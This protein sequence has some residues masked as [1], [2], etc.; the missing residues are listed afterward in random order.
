MTTRRTILKAGLTAGAVA[1]FSGAL[2]GLNAIAQSAPRVRRSLHGMALDDPDLVAYR[3]FVG[4]ML[5]KDQNDP[6]SWLQYSLMHGKYNGNYRYCPHGDWYFL[7]WHREFVIMYE[8]AAMA[9]TGKQDFAMPYWDWSIDRVMPQAFTDPTYQGKPNPLYVPGRT[10]NTSNWPLPDAWVAPEVLA[11]KVYAETNFQLF[12]TSKNP[13]QND[14]D[15]RWVVRGGGSQGFLEGTPHNL[16]HNSIGAYMPTAGSP[17]DPIFMMHHSN[18]DRIWAV[19]NALGRS[20]TADMTPSDRNLWLNMYFNANYLSP[21]GQVYGAYP[22][23]LQD[24]RVLGYTYPN[25]P[26]PD[27]LLSDPKRDA[28]LMSLLAAGSNVDTLEVLRVLPAANTEAATVR[29]PLVKRVQLSSALQSMVV[30]KAESDPASAE[31]FALIREMQ[32]GPDVSSV[33]VFV[34]AE[35]PSANTP[36]SDPHFA[37]EIGFLAHPDSTD[38]H[39]G[40]EGHEKAPPTALLEI[41]DTVR[42]LA[43]LGM[44]KGDN[45]SVSLLPVLRNGARDGAGAQVVPAVVE[46]VVV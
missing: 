28:R 46:I 20:N 43:K 23:D 40:H 24:T 1:V 38:G 33:R 2:G 5:A 13:N 8:N 26:A 12:G 42:N 45:I 22:R 17:R 18:I 25:L 11:K 6:V 37:G 21:T 7:P 35:S 9:I 39:S 36:L 32:V 27:N 4:I 34:N 14:L 44:L 31:V 29:E 16:I 30:D 41:T 3:D 15:M 10:L 19:W